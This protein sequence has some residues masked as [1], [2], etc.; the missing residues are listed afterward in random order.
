MELY[1]LVFPFCIIG[2]L[3]NMLVI[4]AFI[5]NSEVAKVYEYQFILVF[6]VFDS[7]TT[8]SSLLPSLLYPENS[9]IC[10][11]QGVI[12]QISSLSGI[13]WIG[14]IAVA[15]LKELV[16]LKPRFSS[17]FFKPL[18]TI[19][20]ISALSSVLPIIF[21]AYKISG[22]WCWFENPG[23]HHK[24]RDYL[25]RFLLFYIFVWSVIIFNFIVTI[26]VWYKLKKE[27][28]FDFVGNRLVNRLKWY[29][30]VL[31]ICYIPLTVVRISEGMGSMPA[32]FQVFSGIMLRL[33]S[34]FNAIIFFTFDKTNPRSPGSSKLSMFT[35]SLKEIETNK[36][37]KDQLIFNNPK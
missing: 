25:L 21:N 23:E 10:T 16:L 8:L 37:T 3:S 28:I 4:I 26:A 14:L 35:N 6:S 11:M 13:L 1:Y 24:T 36:V 12:I 29:P 32:G 9:I 5:R 7:F 20:S 18:L 15:I 19:V 22:N 31:A 2:A 34:L 17:G 33:I 27:T 30:W